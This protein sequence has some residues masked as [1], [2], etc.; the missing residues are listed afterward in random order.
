MQHDDL[1]LQALALDRVGLPAGAL[2]EP[3]AEGVAVTGRDPLE[4]AEVVELVVERGPLVAE[5]LHW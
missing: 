5:D 3:G 1:V 4:R 2:E